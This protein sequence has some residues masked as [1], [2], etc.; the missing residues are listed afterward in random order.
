MLLYKNKQ[1]KNISAK[2]FHAIQAPFK[3]HIHNLTEDVKIL[4]IEN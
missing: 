3:A 1:T 2:S 4:H